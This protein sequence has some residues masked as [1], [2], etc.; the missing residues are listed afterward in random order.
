MTGDGSIPLFQGLD[1]SRSSVAIVDVL[2]GLFVQVA[3]LDDGVHVI[4]QHGKSL[5]QGLTDLLE[6]F[7]FMV[8][9][10]HGHFL[11]P[12]LRL[13]FFHGLLLSVFFVAG[14]LLF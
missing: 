4:V 10:I 6:S 13:E 1:K 12:Q 8:Q 2:D 11:G 5:V 7:Q 3:G 9:T 14:F